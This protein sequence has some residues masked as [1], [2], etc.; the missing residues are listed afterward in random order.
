MVS[1]DRDD[2]LTSGNLSRSHSGETLPCDDFHLFRNLSLLS[3]NLLIH[4]N[5]LFLNDG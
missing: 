3:F 1:I 2:D 4:F 5:H